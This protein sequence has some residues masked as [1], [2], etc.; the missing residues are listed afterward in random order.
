M[1]KGFERIPLTVRA[2]GDLLA[3]Q[4]ALAV[5]SSQLPLILISDIDVQVV[6]GLHNVQPSVVP[7]LAV[8]FTF[9]ILKGQ[10]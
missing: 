9:G 6:G 4:S 8:Q 5:L 10:K 1:E 3:L 7:R 2:D